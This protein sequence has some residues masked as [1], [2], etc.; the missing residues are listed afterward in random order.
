MLYDNEEI[1]DEK[2]DGYGS[3]DLTLSFGERRTYSDKFRGCY[4]MGNVKKRFLSI[5]GQRQGTY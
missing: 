4:S 3:P 2:E 5:L 1:G